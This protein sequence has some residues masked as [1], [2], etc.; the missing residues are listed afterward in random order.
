MKNLCSKRVLLGS[1]YKMTWHT[2]VPHGVSLVIGRAIPRNPPRWWA[3]RTSAHPRENLRS[4][5]K[6]RPDPVAPFLVKTCTSGSSREEEMW[7]WLFSDVSSPHTEVFETSWSTYSPPILFDHFFF[8]CRY[9]LNAYC[10]GRGVG[11]VEGV[12]LFVIVVWEGHPE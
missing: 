12:L 5:G 3:S 8:F 4:L 9:I 11:N 1:F 10:V 6:A 7:V 2:W